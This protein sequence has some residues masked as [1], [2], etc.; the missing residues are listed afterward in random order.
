MISAQRRLRSAKTHKT[1]ELRKS[2]I[3][4]LWYPDFQKK[5]F[6][7][8]TASPIQGKGKIAPTKTTN[9]VSCYDKF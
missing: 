9:A 6:L 8:E 7:Q 1:L 2:T 5:A 4:S 3:V